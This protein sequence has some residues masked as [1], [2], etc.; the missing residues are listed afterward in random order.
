MINID[1]NCFADL[2]SEVVLNM[3][4]IDF[5]NYIEISVTLTESKTVLTTMGVTFPTSGISKSE[6]ND[7]LRALP[8]LTNDFTLKYLNAIRK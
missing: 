1:A 4:P 6:M 7:W 8:P 5:L 3:K 2:E